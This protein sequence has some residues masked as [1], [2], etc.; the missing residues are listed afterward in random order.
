MELQGVLKTNRAMAYFRL[1]KLNVPELSLY[2]VIAFGLASA[3]ADGLRYWLV[4]PMFLMFSMC[5]SLLT[6][7]LDDIMGFLD[8]V[9]QRTNLERKQNIYK[10]LVTGE[11]TLT[12]AERAARVI[13]GVALVLLGALAGMAHEQVMAA[14]LLLTLLCGVT[15]YSFGLKLSY[16]GMGELVIAAGTA[17]TTALPVWL[18]SGELP[19]HVR[20]I[21]LMSGLPYCAQIV[22]SNLVDHEAD[23]AMGRRT[24]TVMM[25]PRRAPWLSVGLLALFWTLYGLGLG[26]G[27]LPLVTLLWLPLL[28]RHLRFLWM[29]LEGQTA[30]ARLLSFRTIRLQLVLF[31]AAPLLLNHVLAP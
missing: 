31:T 21:A 4:L 5:C 1:L 27:V 17:M 22:I 30:A 20:W 26:L 15:Q 11:L 8:G 3:H 23:A 14:V 2:P 6:I 16:R 28:P 10:P 12:E 24:L 25:G 19:A 13:L 7:V 29:V 9:D 18:E